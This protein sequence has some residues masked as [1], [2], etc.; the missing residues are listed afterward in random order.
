M[1]NGYSRLD[2][3]CEKHGTTV[4]DY[5]KLQKMETLGLLRKNALPVRNGKDYWMERVQKLYSEGWK[6]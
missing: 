1:H 3:F 4:T 5:A 6:Q 2:E